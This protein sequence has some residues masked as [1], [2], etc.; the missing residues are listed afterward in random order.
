MPKAQG[1]SMKL[2]PAKAAKMAAQRDTD[3]P[4]L[5]LTMVISSTTISHGINQDPSTQTT[6]TE[7]THSRGA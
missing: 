4:N 7:V 6:T 3:V 1:D 2:I 5:N